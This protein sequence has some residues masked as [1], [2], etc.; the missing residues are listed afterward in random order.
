MKKTMIKENKTNKQ[1]NK[2]TKTATTYNVPAYI[3]GG[4]A[5]RQLL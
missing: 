3:T 2:Q 4:Y 5:I 1:T